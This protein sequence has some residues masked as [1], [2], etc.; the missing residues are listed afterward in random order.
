MNFFRK[1]GVS[2]LRQL[3]PP[4]SNL[5]TIKNCFVL[6]SKPE[7]RRLRIVSISQLFLAFL[8]F[9]GVLAIGVIG[10]LSV[11]G[12]QS[13]TPSGQLKWILENLRIQNWSLQNQV[14]VIGVLA[15]IL[16]ISKSV[17]S[18][19]MSRRTIF[20]LSNR[21]ADISIRILEKLA[22]SNLEQIKRRSRFENI[23][24][25]TNGVQSI[26]VGVIGTLV[27]LFADVV[28][29]LVMF[30]GLLAID[31]SIAIST[32]CLFGL[33]A[34]SLYKLV[35]K[36]IASLATDDANVQIKNSQLLYELFGSYREV[37]AGGIRNKYVF[38]LGQLRR[39]SAEISANLTFIPNVSKYVLEISFVFGA[40]FFVGIQFIL[41]DAVGAISSISIFVA[42][43]G[44]VIPAILRMQ[45]AALTFR[46]ALSGASRTLEIIEELKQT[47][48]DK[49]QII[50]SEKERISFLPH[51]NLVSVDFK[52]ENS[53]KNALNKINFEIPQ[54]EW[55]AIVGPSGSGKTT[56]VDLI[57]GILK[58]TVGTVTVSGVDPEEAVTNWPGLVSYVPQETFL[59]Q[60]TLEDNVAL[61]RDINEIDSERVIECIEQVGLLDLVNNSLKGVKLEV[62]ELGSRLSGGQRQRLGIARALYTNPKLLILDEATSALDTLSEKHIVDCLKDLKGSVTIVSIAHRLST[63]VS[64]DRVVYIDKGEIIALGT[65][66]EVRNAVPNFD[67]QVKLTNVQN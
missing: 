46:G 8:D 60:G 16:L 42:S 54:G 30:F 34:I 9:A 13:R 33:I 15:G 24:A 29:I 11:Y 6:L 57:L 12:I 31:S 43:A 40:I 45:T 48:S 2:L 18:A 58:P 25:V 20:F 39:K 59:M 19:Y 10:M 52:Y 55:L 4:N 44:R 38:R 66:E 67:K 21:S 51:I 61:G 1:V 32:V 41:K 36:R 5:K 65:F 14:A 37:F 27:N 47:S 7:I 23:F 64:A 62:G 49:F 3:L 53:E 22:F 28:L 56:L 35:N 63:V 26:T 17:I 50:D